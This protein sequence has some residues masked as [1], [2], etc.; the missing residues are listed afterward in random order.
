MLLAETMQVR[1]RLYPRSNNSETSVYITEYTKLRYP[2]CGL[3]EIHFCHPANQ[4]EA[5][6]SIMI[7]GKIFFKKTTK[8]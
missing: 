3:E 2:K 5:G 1:G 4:K 7:C 6:I 8:I